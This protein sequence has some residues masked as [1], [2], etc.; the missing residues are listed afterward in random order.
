MSKSLSIILPVCNAESKLADKVSRLLGVT[1][2]LTNDLELMIV[3][4]GSTDNTE[5]VA[6]ELSQRH[7]QVNNIRFSE[8]CGKI[9]AVNVGI[10]RT[11]GDVIL[12]QNIDASISADAVRGLWEMRQ[13]EALVFSRKESAHSGSA[14]AMHSRPTWSGGTQMV[15]RETV[16]EQSFVPTPPNSKKADRVTRTDVSTNPSAPT[17]FQ[18][19]PN[20]EMQPDR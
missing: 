3:D 17:L 10:M 8:P 6:I 9:N 14:P 18:Q 2:D 4:D 11:R 7:S 19:M 16:N 15:R 20:A 5:E 12:I 13:E 1:A